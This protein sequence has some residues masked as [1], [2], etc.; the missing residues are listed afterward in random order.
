M[1]SDLAPVLRDGWF[2]A[3]VVFV[4]GW[5][6]DH[7]REERG[8]RALQSALTE[9]RA[10]H[11]V[12]HEHLEAA[13][14]KLSA[15]QAELAVIRRDKAEVDAELARLNELADPNSPTNQRR[16]DQARWDK[17]EEQRAAL[18][19]EAAER[20]DLENRLNWKVMENLRYRRGVN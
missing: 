20:R 1:L 6:L 16:A 3:L 5:L 15:L 9:S 14:G 4:L 8:R 18:E 17:Q 2:I 13:H 19:R 11:E 7:V 12:T 10:A